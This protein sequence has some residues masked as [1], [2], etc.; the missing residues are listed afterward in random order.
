MILLMFVIG[1]LISTA[2]VLIVWWVIAPQ[3]L[4]DWGESFGAMRPRSEVVSVK[5]LRGH[6]VPVDRFYVDQRGELR[7]E[8]RV[9]PP[10]PGGFK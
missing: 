7:K 3:S 2:A 9:A 1:C 6:E 5:N 8:R 4:M 10:E